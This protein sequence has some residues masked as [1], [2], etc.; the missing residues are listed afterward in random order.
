MSENTT[1][2]DRFYTIEEGGEAAYIA[3]IFDDIA[4]NG[5]S[6][7]TLLHFLDEK[8]YQRLDEETPGGVYDGLLDAI[9]D[10]QLVVRTPLSESE[11]LAARLRRHL[12]KQKLDFFAT[13]INT[14]LTRIAEGIMPSWEDT[15]LS[16]IY[17]D[18]HR[19]LPLVRLL[20]DTQKTATKL[21]NKYANGEWFPA[22]NTGEEMILY[23]A[24]LLAEEELGQFLAGAY[25]PVTEYLLNN[26]DFL[27]YYE[28]QEN[29]GEDYVFDEEEFLNSLA[30]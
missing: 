23:S 24:Y 5:E 21:A 12:P 2:L 27:W 4:E 29:D 28:N 22:R 30:G 3:H 25:S 15:I 11:V 8:S 13:D 9:P 16:Y 20:Q 1:S 19:E 14:T 17:P 6:I 10:S 26:L 18:N 7:Y